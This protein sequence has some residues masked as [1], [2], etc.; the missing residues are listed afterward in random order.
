MDT[1]TED[2]SRAITIH[3]NDSPSFRGKAGCKDLTPRFSSK[4]WRAIPIDQPAAFVS[5][6]VI[7]PLY[8]VPATAAAGTVNEPVARI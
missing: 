1:K 3:W 7:T 8:V 2:H 5:V 4:G 6:T